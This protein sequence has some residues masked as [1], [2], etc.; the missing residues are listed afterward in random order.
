[1]DGDSFNLG[2]DKFEFGDI[3]SQRLRLGSRIESIDWGVYFGAA[4][5]REF[6]GEATMTAAGMNAPVESL[7]GNSFMGELGWKHQMTMVPLSVDLKATGW[8]GERSGVSGQLYL[9]YEF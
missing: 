2:G 1:M 7:K 4:Y 8:T 9:A 3:S 6:D 5:E